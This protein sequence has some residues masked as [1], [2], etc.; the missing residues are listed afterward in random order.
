MGLLIHFLITVNLYQIGKKTW[1]GSLLL[2]GWLQISAWISNYTRS[3]VRD[4]YSFL[5]F[6]GATVEVQV[7]KSDLTPHWACD[8][9]SVRWL[10]LTHVSKRDPRGW[11]VPLTNMHISYFVAFRTGWYYLY[12]LGLHHSHWGNQYGHVW[13]LYLHYMH[14]ICA[15]RLIDSEL[16]V[17]NNAK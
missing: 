8:Y 14:L 12:F 9:F 15:V 1:G 11:W 16:P 2:Y 4:T 10:K 6:K 5:N 3:K 13:F 7:S 17:K